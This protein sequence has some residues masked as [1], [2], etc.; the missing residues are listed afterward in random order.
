MKAIPIRR[1]ARG[2]IACAPPPPAMG[3]MAPP[4]PLASCSPM[5]E[6]AAFDGHLMEE[7]ESATSITRKAKCA[8]PKG[9]GAGAGCVDST[10][11][12][13]AMGMRRE[14]RLQSEAA[15]PGAT[16]PQRSALASPPDTSPSGGEWEDGGVA[17]EEGAVDFTQIPA[18]LDSQF[19]RHDLD[20]ALRPT[21]LLVGGE[22]SRY[23]QRALLGK[24]VREHLHGEQQKDEKKKAYDLLDALSRS[25]ALPLESTSL[26]VVRV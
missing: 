22:W 16:P 19:E 13:E 17:L 20:A 14:D 11:S 15:R 1:S 6:C 26:H 10:S 9:R 12:V 8:K 3:G 18:A 23:V 2:S 25:G 4:I 5:V 24:P 21:R 7:A